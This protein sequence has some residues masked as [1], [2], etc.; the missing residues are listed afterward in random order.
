MGKGIPRALLC[1]FLVVMAVMTSSCTSITFQG[2]G[3]I[4]LYLTP[5][6]DHVSY[7]EIQ[8]QKE[9]YLWGL[10]GPDD[11][12]FLDEVFYESGLVSV[13]AVDIQEYQTSAS[14]WK[15]VFSL[16]FYIPKD[17]MVSGHGVSPG[18]VK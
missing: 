17:Y 7:V 3:L 4:P 10:I 15:A 5:R 8:G 9:F 11:Q 14:F 18:S 6:P 1:L 16:G 12:V 2:K 13:A